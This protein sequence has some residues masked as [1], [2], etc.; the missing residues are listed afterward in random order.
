MKDVRD[1]PQKFPDF[2]IENA[3]LK[4]GKRLWNGHWKG[5]LNAASITAEVET[6]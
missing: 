4:E 1:D 2:I 5:G 3:V 6:R